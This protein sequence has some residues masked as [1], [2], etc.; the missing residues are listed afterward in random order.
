MKRFLKAKEVAS[1]AYTLLYEQPY[2]NRTII[3]MHGGM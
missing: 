3:R 1:M 2:V